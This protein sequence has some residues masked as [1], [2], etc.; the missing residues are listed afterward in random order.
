MKA[1]RLA[2]TVQGLPTWIRSLLING[3]GFVQ[4]RR[5][6]GSEF[7]RFR[8]FL[9]ESQFWSPDRLREFQLERVRQILHRA[10]V[11]SPFYRRRFEA[12]GFRPEKMNCLGDLAALPVLTRE[13]LQQH[14]PEILCHDHPGSTVKRCTSGTTGVRLELRVPRALAFGW[15]AAVLW[16]QYSWAGIARGDRRVTLG[17]RWFARRPPFWTYNRF[18]DQLLLSTHHLNE[19]TSGSYLEEMARFQPKFIQ[20]HPSAVHFLAEALLQRKRVLP[21][22]AVFTTGETLAP[23]LRG[24][25]EQAFQCRVFED[26]GHGELA[27]AAQECEHHCGFHEVSEFGF[28]ELVWSDRLQ[29]HEVIATSLWNTAMPL[30]RYRTNDLAELPADEAACACGRGLPLKINRLFGRVDDNLP[31][32]DGRTIFAVTLRTALRPW[33]KPFESYQVRRIGEGEYEFLGTVQRTSPEKR[34][35]AE[36]LQAVL[37]NRARIEVGY[38]EQIRTTGGKVRTVVDLLKPGR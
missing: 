30:I 14:G 10:E 2:V 38:C 21:L 18:E 34:Q 23:E 13:E 1:D 15:R 7:A 37:G 35:L 5:R 17:G 20:G 16:R 22:K 4:S 26:Y 36:A 27:A 12:A 11:G 8:D 9:K 32:P 24:P 28:L 29:R 25:I 6:F 33:L 19:S 31:G 3:Y